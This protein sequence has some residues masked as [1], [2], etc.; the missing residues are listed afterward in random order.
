MHTLLQIL[1]EESGIVI[2]GKNQNC[3][4]LI[5]DHFD[6]QLQKLWNPYF[7]HFYKLIEGY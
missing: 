5:F 4:P 6:Q 3:L 1:L 2:V 7:L